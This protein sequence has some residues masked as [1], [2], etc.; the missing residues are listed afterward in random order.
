VTPTMR[1]LA[2]NR[3]KRLSEGSLVEAHVEG[4]VLGLRLLKI[5]ALVALV[6]ASPAAFEADGLVQSGR[7]MSAVRNGSVVPG[8]ALAEAVR[9]LDEA[10]VLLA[11]DR[12]NGS[13]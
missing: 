2:F 1:S 10:T 7:S 12:R 4:R 9:T 13:K 6:P 3:G 5:D 11:D 8:S